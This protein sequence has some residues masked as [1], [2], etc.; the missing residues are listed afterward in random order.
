MGFMSDCPPW[1]SEPTITVKGMGFFVKHWGKQWNIKVMHLQNHIPS[2]RPCSTFVTNL[3]KTP[4]LLSSPHPISN[5]HSLKDALPAHPDDDHLN[6][7]VL[8][9]K[10][11]LHLKQLCDVFISSSISK[12]AFTTSRCLQCYPLGICH[13]G[14]LRSWFHSLNPIPAVHNYPLL[15]A[16]GRHILWSMHHLCPRYAG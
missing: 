13:S 16:M 5:S 10:G 1:R 14:L 9:K 3:F 2:C 12:R 11:L 8:T 15:R 4:A 6:S 7:V